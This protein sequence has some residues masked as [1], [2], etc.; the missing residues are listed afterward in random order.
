MALLI[1]HLLKEIQLQLS[2]SSI[3]PAS[4]PKVDNSTAASISHPSDL[5]VVVKESIS[6]SSSSNPNAVEQTVSTGDG[7]QVINYGNVNNVDNVSATISL[8]KPRTTILAI[9]Q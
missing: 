9:L 1:S 3:T 5:G 8:D 7:V 2:G 6:A 4:R